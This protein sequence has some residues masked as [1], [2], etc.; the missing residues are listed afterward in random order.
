MTFTLLG[1]TFSVKKAE[2]A[3]AAYEWYAG[4]HTQ[5]NFYEQSKDLAVK[6]WLTGR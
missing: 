3:E 4:A 1:L 6:L 2:Q 5:Q